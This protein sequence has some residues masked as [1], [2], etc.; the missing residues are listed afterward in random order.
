MTLSVYLDYNATAPLEEDAFRAMEPYLRDNLATLP[1]CT[2]MAETPAAPWKKRVKK[3][4]MRL[5]RTRMKWS[6]LL[7]ALRA[8]IPLSKALQRCLCAVWSP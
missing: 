8:I 3:W 1:A 5:A 6:L 2:V 7:P 4:R